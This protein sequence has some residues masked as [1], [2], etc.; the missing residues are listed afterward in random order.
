MKCAKY[1][2]TDKGQR[3][4]EERNPR[5]RNLSNRNGNRGLRGPDFGRWDALQVSVRLRE[6]H[7][8]FSTNQIM[9]NRL[10][11]T[12]LLSQI[13]CSFNFKMAVSWLVRVLLLICS[14]FQYLADSSQRVNRFEYK[15]SF[16]GPHLVNKE[17]Q[18]PFWTVGGSKYP[19]TFCYCFSLL[20]CLRTPVFCTRCVPS[21]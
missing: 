15:F 2:R 7:R 9:T 10:F 17:G 3:R 8:R 21:C 1:Q 14:F 12:M 4:I 20:I 5:N 18:V 19:T 16:K 6:N 11:P 13:D